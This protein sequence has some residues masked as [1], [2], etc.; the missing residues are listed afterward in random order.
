[1]KL[2]IAVLPGD[3]VGPEVTRE[4]VRVLRAVSD[5]N[6]YEFEFREYPIVGAAI[7]A[8]KQPLPQRTRDGCL[9]SDAVL[10]GAVGGPQYDA[11]PAELRPEA[12]ILGLRQ[13]LGVFANLRPAIAYEAVADCSPIRAEV[14]R[15]AN[16]LIVRELLGGL[17][18]GLPRGR[19]ERGA[20]DT[21]RYSPQEIERVARIAFEQARNRRHHVTSVD[22][23]NVLETSRLWR[24]VLTDLAREYPDVRLDHA[25]VDSF[26]MQLIS[27]PSRFDV[28]VTENLF[29]DVLSDESAVLSGSLGM[30]G[31][32]SIGGKVGLFEP[33]H[34]SA[35]DIAGKNI[36]NPIGAIASAAMLLR[37]AAG[38]HR[39]ADDVES[40]IALTLE[41]GCVTADLRSEKR[42][43]VATTREVGDEIERALTDLLG[44][45]LAYHAV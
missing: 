42:K 6:G 17:Y 29:G 5:V 7:D 32:A 1:M 23:A 33:I 13:A 43:T 9:E 41:K 45:H 11:L 30:L 44:Q 19:D 4:A 24:Q 21:M 12:G 16:V 35:P 15:G 26:A 27:T 40:A 22:K 34:G 37:F 20:Y 39:D 25:Y 8:G 3:G 18:F 2:K 10:L 14:L 38:L 36:A 31:S 28:V